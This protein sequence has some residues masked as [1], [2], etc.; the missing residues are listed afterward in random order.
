MYKRLFF[1][2]FYP[3]AFL[4]SVPDARAQQSNWQWSVPVSH[5]QYVQVPSR[6]YLWIPVDC[7]KIKAVIFAQNNMEEQSVLENTIFRKAMARL[8]VAEVWVSPAYD[9]LFNFDK[10]AGDVFNGIM[11]DLA[12]V[13]G[14]AELR[15]VPFIGMGHSAAASSPYYMA[16]WNPERALAAISVSGQWPYFRHPSFAPDI[17]G[18]QTIDFIPC[19]ETMGEYEAANTWSAEGLLERQQHPLMPLSMLASPAQGHFAATN[20]K[21]AYIALYIKKAMHYRIPAHTPNDA[22]PKLI[23]VDPTKSGWLVDK[24]RYDQKPEAPAGPVSQ[25]SGDPQ[26]AFWFF[27]EEIAKA[28]VE[29]EATHRF[30]KPQLIGHVQDGKMVAQYNT[31]QQVNLKFEPEADGI[32]FK[33][34]AAF[35]D[36]IGSGS[37]RLAMWAN[38]P[39][40]SAIGHATD[41]GPIVIDR[42]TG[43]VIKV[44]DS[45]FRLSPQQGFWQDPH[46][47]ELWFAAT[48]PGNK[49]YKPA[50]QQAQMLVPPR[51]KDGREQH[52]TF[53]QVA[54]QKPGAKN[55]RLQAV[56]DAKVP[57]SFYVQDGPAVIHGNSLDLTAIPPKS[58]FP[59]KVTVVAWQYGNSNEPKLQTAEPVER[60]FWINK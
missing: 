51:N 11:N 40:G 54:G 20:E 8:G 27:D 34:H 33:L 13:S 10:G 59:V 12:D 17:W 55:I 25:Y 22:A 1:Y 3:L 43:P 42:I 30:Q 7:K 29:Y 48:H 24:W 36:T 6:A 2:L 19:L 39:A 57:V 21:C 56:S 38:M 47:Y 52:I 23:P 9:L 49:D 28:T 46:S 14:Y 16:A 58:K 60:V 26:Q 41:G 31:H 5:T 45:T 44:D 53:L 4:L 37:P 50:V 18:K 15:Y 32:T 35:Y